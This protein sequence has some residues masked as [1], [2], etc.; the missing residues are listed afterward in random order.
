M[1]ERMEAHWWQ[2]AILYQIYVRSFYDSDGDGIGDLR[3]VL[4]KLDYLESLGVTAIW[5]CPFYPSPQVD[6]GY[7]VIDY[8]NVDPIFGTL[9]IFDELIAEVHRRKMRLLVD[10]VPN[11]TSINHPWFEAARSSVRDPHRDWYIWSNPSETGGPPTNWLSEQGDSGWTWEAGTKQYYFHSF[12]TEQPDLNWRHPRVRLAMLDAMSFWLDRGVDGFRIDA[13]PYLIKDDRFRNNPPNPNHD[14]PDLAPQ[15]IQ[16]H[17][18]DQDRPEVHDV[19]G[20]FRRLVDSYGE[21]RILIGETYLPPVKL[22]GYYGARGLTF[23][24]NFQL[25]EK[26]WNLVNVRSSIDALESRLP[27]GDWPNWVLGNHDRSRFASRAGSEYARMAA[28]ILMTL[29]GTPTIYYGEEVGMSDIPVSPESSLDAMGRRCGR[30]RDPERSPM[31]WSND[32]AGGFTTG[33]PWLPLADDFETVNARRQ[34]QDPDSLLTLY[35]RIIT[36]RQASR[37]L[38]LGAYRSFDLNPHVLAYSRSSPGDDWF[39]MANF[40]REPQ[41]I[42]VPMKFQGGEIHISTS[43]HDRRSPVGKSFSLGPYEAVVL[44]T[45]ATEGRPS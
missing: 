28:V 15:K 5:L 25:V 42:D 33:H 20:W 40:C 44:G 12:L 7:D 21:D 31:Q 37:A 24:F 18:F 43:T 10:F 6:F 1:S 3:G 8:K 38:M 11:H 29:R 36:L 14:E 41:D 32:T 2:T 45:P 27:G 34:G 16:L 17:C 4:M 13:A 35:R 23:P 22:I 9:E 19:I 39:V 30:S 26:P